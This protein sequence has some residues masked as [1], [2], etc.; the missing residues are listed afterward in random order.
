MISDLPSRSRS[1]RVAAE[2]ALVRIIH[3]YGVLPEFVLLGGL[4]PEML[5]ADSDF[6]HAGTTDVDVQVNLEIAQGS[7]NAA[8]LERALQNAGFIPEDGKIWRWVADR[9]SAGTVIKFELLADL[10]WCEEGTIIR[11]DECDSLGAANLRGTAYA[12]RGAEVHDLRARIGGVDCYAQVNVAGL[13][14]FLFANVAAAFSRRATKDRYDIA[15]VLLHND[16]GGPSVAATLVRDLFADDLCTVQTALA[17]LQANFADEAAQG[18]QAYVRQMRVDHP[19]LDSVT[20]AADATVAVQNF[21]RQ[22]LL[23]AN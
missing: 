16:A 8:R 2:T 20:L 13:A 18:S 15:F 21:L 11:F 17:D 23:P 6:R 1:A 19:E 4:V 9:S 12:T 10:D 7:F 3:H 5:C 22:L 14:G